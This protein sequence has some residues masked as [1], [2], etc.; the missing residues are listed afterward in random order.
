[1]PRD[2]D[3]RPVAAGRG[4]VQPARPARLPVRDRAHGRRRGSRRHL[5]DVPG[6]RPA[7]IGT[8]GNCGLVLSCGAASRSRRPRRPA[9]RRRGDRLT[10]R[11]LVLPA[12]SSPGS[13]WSAPSPPHVAP[14][15]PARER[16]PARERRWLPRRARV[17]GRGRRQLRREV[18]RDTRGRDRQRRRPVRDR[19]RLGRLRLLAAR[20]SCAGSW[21]DAGRGATSTSSASRSRAAIAGGYLFIERRYP[22][23]ALGF[24]PLGL[25]SIASTCTAGRCRTR[26]RRSC[27]R[28]RTRPS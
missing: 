22:V 23:R 2:A 28:S 18:E 14:H 27:R 19:A 7:Q 20:C 17:R 9:A 1:M 11:G 8:C 26:S 12:T 5:P 3:G 10:W 24:L 6:G 25:A 4:A 16:A 15:G 21:W 13:C